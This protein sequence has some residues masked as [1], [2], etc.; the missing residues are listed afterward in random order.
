MA[1]T[2]NEEEKMVKSFQDFFDSSFI[3]HRYSFWL[4]TNH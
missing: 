1:N 2:M 3:N 4:A